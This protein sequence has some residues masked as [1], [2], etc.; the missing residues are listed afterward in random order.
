[1]KA[2]LD[3]AERHLCLARDALERHVLEEA[4]RDDLALIVWQT[5]DRVAQPCGLL[6]VHD[7]C[8]WVGRPIADKV[9]CGV[10]VCR[11]VPTGA[12]RAGNRD[13]PRNAPDPRPKGAVATV[14]G[15]GAE[16]LDERILG[17]VLRLIGIPQH[18]QAH[19][20]HGARLALDEHSVHVPVARQHGVDECS[21][22]NDW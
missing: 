8:E 5:V 4:Q 15:E 6:H 22:V 21:I 16:G 14:A 11:C 1:M 9:R 18:T 17:C 19:A 10:D 20:D 2:R 13:A 7:A 3:C 12:G